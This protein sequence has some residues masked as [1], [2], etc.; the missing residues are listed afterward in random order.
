M[1][2]AW[3]YPP[4]GTSRAMLSEHIPSLMGGTIS[5]L[6]CPPTTIITRH[7]REQATRKK[8]ERDRKQADIAAGDLL[9]EVPVD[10]LRRMCDFLPLGS[11]LRLASVCQALQ[12]LDYDDVAW[13]RRHCF[14]FHLPSES[15]G[16][17]KSLQQ[18]YALT[19]ISGKATDTSMPFY[20]DSEVAGSWKRSYRYKYISNALESGCRKRVCPYPHCHQMLLAKSV[21]ER[22][23]IEKHRL[24]HVAKL[25][26]KKKVEKRAEK[27]AQNREEKKRKRKEE[28]AAKKATKMKIPANERAKK[29]N[30]AKNDSISQNLDATLTTQ[31]VAAATT[32]ST[33]KISKNQSTVTA[34]AEAMVAAAKAVMAAVVASCEQQI[35]L[36]GQNLPQNQDTMSSNET[37][38]NESI[39]AN[40]S[41]AAYPKVMVKNNSAVNKKLMIKSTMN[42]PNKTSAIAQPKMTVKAVESM[43][44]NIAA[45]QEVM[46][47]PVTY[48]LTKT[49][50]IATADD[51]KVDNKK[52][53]DQQGISQHDRFTIP[54]IPPYRPLPLP[55]SCQLISPHPPSHL[56]I[57]SPPPQLHQIIQAYERGRRGLPLFGP[58]GIY[59]GSEDVVS[60][61]G[62]SV[63]L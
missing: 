37:R 11:F 62:D 23:H 24:V 51:H 22:K 30:M 43:K 46:V 57:R 12:S 48:D 7:E 50:V 49:N 21:S 10:V 19:E 34:A 59:L 3:P 1:V 14:Q 60:A 20:D 63:S 26:R 5:P 42:A 15:G 25:E 31:A 58:G 36:K 45:N 39:Q 54:V 13:K 17:D 18:Y 2:D 40:T 47:G 16:E 35:P 55:T 27:L 44:T 29:R 28:A 53:E 32:A 4:E 52:K 38:A 6:P 8:R 9:L 33:R 61:Y 56:I 41:A